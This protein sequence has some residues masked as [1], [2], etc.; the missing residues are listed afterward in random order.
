[1]KFQIM[2]KYNIEIWGL[3][4][5]ILVMAE[6]WSMTLICMFASL[7]AFTVALLTIAVDGMRDI[8]VQLTVFFLLALLYTAIGYRPVK[9]LIRR[10][11]DE[12]YRNITGDTATVLGVPLEPGKTGQVRWSGTDCKAA[13]EGDE[14]ID[15]GVE[16]MITDIRGNIFIVR[17]KKKNE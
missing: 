13:V 14:T 10:N 3:L 4:G 11:A 2:Q 7:S 8:E 17:R 9:K 15:V 16:V 6:I 1:M 5:V 12:Q